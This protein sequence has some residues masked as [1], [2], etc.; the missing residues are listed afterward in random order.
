MQYVILDLEW[1]NAYS[2][3]KAGYINEIIEIGAVK[4][5]ED[6]DTVDTFSKIIRSQ[7]GRKLRGSVKRLTNLTNDDILT[8]EPFSKAF[9]QFKNWMGNE[10]TVIM[11]WGDGDVRTLIENYNYFCG[12]ETVPF[13]HY[14]CDLQRCF[15]KIKKRRPDQQ[16][17]LITAAQEMGI[18]PEG[19]AHHRALGDAQLTADIFEILYD[20]SVFQKEI[21]KCDNEFYERLMY[22]AKVLKNIENPLVDK[23]R[24]E[25]YCDTCGK[26][27]ALVEPW[28]FSCNFFRAKFYCEDCD[29]TYA[30]RV[31]FKKLYDSVDFKKIVTVCNTSEDD[32]EEEDE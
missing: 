7:I 17:G 29:T 26:P 23:K 24:L 9:A 11:S 31:R 14:Y 5:N 1:N 19:Y 12:I 16:A 8:G 25:H 3:K 18:D 32:D 4:I 21:R 28:K 13:L 2:K 15:Q 22:K 27:C 10:K 30:V 20:E 6:L